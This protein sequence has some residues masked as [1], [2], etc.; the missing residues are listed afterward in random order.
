MLRVQGLPHVHA[1]RVPHVEDAASNL[2]HLDDSLP[3]AEAIAT[4]LHQAIERLG[5]NRDADAALY[6]FGLVQGT[7]TFNA[8]DRRAAAAR[9]Q[10][11]SVERF[12]KGYEPRLLKSVATEILALLALTAAVGRPDRVEPPARPATPAPFP[13]ERQVAEI[14]RAAHATADWDLV[15]GVYRQCQEIAKDPH[16]RTIPLNV[17]GFLAEA[18]G[19]IAANYY[20]R[21]EELIVHALGVLG[22]IDESETVSPA[23]FRRLYHDP[24]FARF[25][26]YSG[27]NDAPRRRPRPFEALV[28]TVRRYRDLNSLGLALSKV[29]TSGILGG[30]VNYGRFFTVR[31]QFENDPASDLDLVVVLPDF[32]FLDSAIASLDAVRAIAGEDLRALAERARLFT[33]KDLDDG[34]TVFSHPVPMWGAADDSL[35]AWAPNSGTY[36]L[37][38]RFLSLAALDW[39]LVADS[40]K[41]NGSSAGQTRSVR[42]YCATNSSNE[43]HHRSFGGHNLRSQLE[44]H[45]AEGGFLRSSRVYQIDD[46]RYYPGVFQNLVLPRF[47]QR[48]ESVPISGR[49]EA[50][51]WKIT[52]RL[53]WERRERPY[54]MLRLSLSHI[55][56]ELFAPHVLRSVDG[57]DTSA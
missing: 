25:R 54:E 28:E 53:R 38:V 5:E 9:A 18:F 40:S 50:F 8:T 21:E 6:T 19:R 3:L 14:L 34:R 43:D 27:A 44:M 26:Q 20:D 57:A 56:S 2:G 4:L 49:L 48:W 52:E 24:R 16:G 29:P 32:G 12:R 31:G 46:D 17:A 55:R 51:R 22:N 36:R 11:V 35:M 47:A 13:V 30:S 10:G 37:D 42:D 33:E 41:L 39:L 23:L 7:K 1:I 15:E 45:P